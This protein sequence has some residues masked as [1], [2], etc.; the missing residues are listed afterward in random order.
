MIVSVGFMFYGS[1]S[2]PSSQDLEEISEPNST[3]LEMGQDSLLRYKTL[4]ED[5]HILYQQNQRMM[6]FLP[7]KRNISPPNINFPARNSLHFSNR[8]KLASSAFYAND[9]PTTSI[10]NNS[11]S[12]ANM[13]SVSIT[14]NMRY[15]VLKLSFKLDM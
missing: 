12:A 7:R 2:V 6:D 15:N 11:G 8:L 1:D 10:P 9:V 13:Y 5:H 4:P 3:E 14:T